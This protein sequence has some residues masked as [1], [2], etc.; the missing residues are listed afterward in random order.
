L[1]AR[2]GAAVDV[3]AVNV[4]VTA[5]LPV[6]EGIIGSIIAVD[7]GPWRVEAGRE[8]QAQLRRRGHFSLGFSTNIP[9]ISV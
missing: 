1:A 9:A 3:P 8:R 7:D 5:Q 2:N 4:G 6:V